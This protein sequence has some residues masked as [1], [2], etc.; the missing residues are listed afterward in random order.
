M[1]GNFFLPAFAIYGHELIEFFRIKV[2]TTPVDVLIAGHPAERTL[3]R[4]TAAM[5]AI[6]NPLQHA[7]IFAES[8]P[9]KFSLLIDAE[10]VDQKNARRIEDAPSHL[11][12]VVEVIT[13]VITAEWQ[14]RHRVAPDFTDFSCGSGGSFRTHSR[15]KID[16]EIPVDCLIHQ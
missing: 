12:P 14:H 1:C 4:I 6:D 7:H 13:H 2:Q 11:Q 5:N 16:P 15:S 10:P 8:R 3:D 9:E